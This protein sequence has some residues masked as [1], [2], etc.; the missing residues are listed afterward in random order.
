MEKICNTCDVSKPVGDFRNR[1]QC[2]EYFELVAENITQTGAPVENTGDWFWWINFNWH[3]AGH[4]WYAY[5]QFPQKNPANY[6]FYQRRYH[7]WYNS[8]AYQQW[9]FGAQGRA[10][11]H[12][13]SISEYKMPAKQYI[14][15]VVPNAWYMEFKTKSASTTRFNGLDFA[16]NNTSPRYIKLYN[17]TAANTTVG[18]TTPRATG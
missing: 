12:F 10:A 14:N 7:A 4:L 11:K 3:W 13:D 8:L 6:Q 18:A 5:V 9:S 2:A 17:A 1:N 16:N 15:S